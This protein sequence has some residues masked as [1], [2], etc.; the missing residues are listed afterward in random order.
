MHMI[1]PK[2]RCVPYH[3]ARGKLLHLG[4]HFWKHHL[5]TFGLIYEEKRVLSTKCTAGLKWWGLQFWV[6]H[7]N[8]RLQ[9]SVV[10]IYR[11]STF[12]EILLSFIFHSDN[13]T[14]SVFVDWTP[15]LFGC[16]HLETHNGVNQEQLPIFLPSCPK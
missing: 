1:S 16:L 12:L 14:K 11:Y 10:F 4:F 3:I 9:I 13:Y 7:N 2:I 8:I 5:K 15:F 6:V